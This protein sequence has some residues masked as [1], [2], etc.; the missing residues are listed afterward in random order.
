MEDDRAS[1]QRP[2]ERA[3]SDPAGLPTEV[4]RV[5]PASSFAD[6]ELRPAGQ[7]YGDADL[8]PGGGLGGGMMMGERSFGRPGMP[9]G[10]PRTPGD[11]RPRFGPAD[12]YARFDPIFPGQMPPGGVGPGGRGPRAPR[13]PGEPDND[14]FAPPLGRP[15]EPF[16][17]PGGGQFGPRQGGG[18]GGGG[19]GGSSPWT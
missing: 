17:G 6:V 2:A 14:L 16:G 15:G 19:W 10:L 4:R 9:S 1:R 13:L 3:A 11:D 7:R 5:A 18:P 12:G 8:V